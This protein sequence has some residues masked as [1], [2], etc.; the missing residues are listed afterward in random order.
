MPK[1]QIRDTND[2]IRN[3][4]YLE[5]MVQDTGIGIA[6][7]NLPVVFDLFKQVD[8]NGSERQD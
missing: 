4:R 7:Q 8:I 1:D 2:D 6:E 5:F 3:T